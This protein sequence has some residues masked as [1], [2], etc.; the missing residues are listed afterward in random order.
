M[1]AKHPAIMPGL[2][3]TPGPDA[4]RVRHT[5]AH[6]VKRD[7]TG[8]R[9]HRLY[10]VLSARA[11]GVE[12]ARTTE[13]DALPVQVVAWECNLRQVKRLGRGFAMLRAEPATRRAAPRES[14]LQAH[15]R[16]CPACATAEYCRDARERWGLL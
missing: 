16:T 9:R 8:E 6:D 2:G 15:L 3:Y 1:H 11:V 5:W 13:R 7:F 14:A 4:K 12:W 10:Q